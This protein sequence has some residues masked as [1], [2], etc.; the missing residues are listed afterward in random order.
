LRADTAL[1]LFG[2]AFW[3][4]LQERV[5]ERR[6][7]AWADDNLSD[8]N[9][10]YGFHSGYVLDADD[11]QIY[12]VVGGRRDDRR[13][14]DLLGAPL[15]ALLHETRS[16]AMERPVSA[17]TF[18]S[19]DGQAL[20]V[21]ACAI[22][23]Q[24]PR[25]DELIPHPRPVLVGIRALDEGVLRALSEDLL[26]P[27]LHVA[28]TPPTAESAAVALPGMPGEPA[29]A[30]LV[31]NAEPPASRLLPVLAT[32]AFVTMLVCAGLASLMAIGIARTTSRVSESLE[33]LAAANAGLARSEEGER[34][35]RFRAEEA[36]RAKSVFLANASRELRTPLNA[37]IGLSEIILMKAGRTIDAAEFT[38]RVSAIRDSGVSLLQ[39][40]NDLIDLSRAEVGRQ[41]IEPESLAAVHTLDRIRRR[42]S[43][44]AEARDIQ[45]DIACEE[46]EIAFWADPLAFE[47]VAA[48]L[49]SNAVA[50]S[51]PGGRVMV[52]ARADTGGGVELVVRDFG[53]GFDPQAL[54][55][56]FQPFSSGPVAGQGSD[57]GLAI[58]KALMGLHHGDAT[59]E[60]EPGRGTTVRAVFPPPRREKRPKASPDEAAGRPLAA[61]YTAFTSVGG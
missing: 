26:I 15:A 59:I 2:Y 30:W 47:R 31:W 56:I 12:G 14:L 38:A 61:T 17:S 48:N 9:G 29:S 43:N 58:V 1:L 54:A 49:I 32:A 45:I 40:I 57:L 27:G 51:R 35:A 41:K 39:M 36:S 37:I 11:A 53:E 4:V 19:H 42:L 13:V 28:M 33:R 34:A 18:L 60:S 8:L 16:S 24:A 10:P 6:D 5:V 25:G 50:S 7:L 46:P 22:S 23:H 3:D 52:E 21:A 20:I 55:N 44:V